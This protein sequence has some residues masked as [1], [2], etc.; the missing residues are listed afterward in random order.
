MK[1]DI[2]MQ[3]KDEWKPEH[4]NA[5]HDNIDV[6]Q[7]KTRVPNTYKGEKRMKHH[8]LKTQTAFYQE[9]ERGVKNFEIRKNDRDFQVRDVV[10]LLEYV[11]DVPTGRKIIGMQVKCIFHG[12]QYGL[13]EGYCILGF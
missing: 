9:V 4:L 7:S 5:L 6:G 8:E 2:Q 1:A 12:G 11:G 13:E 10:S 3:S